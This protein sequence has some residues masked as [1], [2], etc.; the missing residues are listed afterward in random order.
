MSLKTRALG[1]LTLALFPLYVGFGLFVRARQIRLAPAALPRRHRFGGEGEALRL[2]FLGDS[3]VAGVGTDRLEDGLGAQIARKLS[4]G[5]GRPVE[6]VAYGFNS[7]TTADLLTVALPA[8]GGEDPHI[9]VMVVGVNDAKN[10][11]SHGAFRRDFGRLCYMLNARFPEAVLAH[12]SMPPMAIFPVLPTVLRLILDARRMLLDETA[13]RLCKERGL[14]R[15]PT[16]PDVTPDWFAE[17]RFHMNARGYRLWAEAL[18][19]HI[20]AEDWADEAL[21]LRQRG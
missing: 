4:E 20:L 13:A 2:L 19:P 7:A 21:A 18:V 12:V 14:K 1:F 3:S 8:I 9:A 16:G 10:F 6:A 11:R 5:L 15:L 17:D